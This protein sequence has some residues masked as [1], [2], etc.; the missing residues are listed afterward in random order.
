MYALSIC[1][2]SVRQFDGLYSL[3]DLHVASGSLAKNKPA[4]FL[5]LGQTK[6]LISEIAQ[7]GNHHLALKVKHGGD[8]RGTFA[9]KE[10]VYAYAMWISP[11]FMLHVIRTFD[12][13]MTNKT[14]QQIQT[15]ITPAQQRAIQEAVNQAVHDSEGRKHHRMLYGSLKTTFGIARYDQL[16]MARFDDAIALLRNHKALPNEA[17]A[18]PKLQY[19][20]SS[21]HY[22]RDTGLSKNIVAGS[23]WLTG[24]ELMSQRYSSP[25]N[26]LLSQLEAD[27]HD[28]TGA[29]I[30]Y[31]G[32][33]HQVE[34]KTHLIQS[35]ISDLSASLMQ[36]MK[37]NVNKPPA[38]T[39]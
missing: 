39:H 37:I 4:E 23:C 33:K 36:G 29:K 32:L 20:Q 25:I 1:S 31:A 2:T 5:R 10:L 34:A 6:D 30:E 38:M 28:I 27:G 22:P 12:S 19:K 7:D 8:N 21:Y 11:A 15:T 17:Q 14:A 3:N 26:K 24:A 16:P 13:L 18:K 9:C 35:V